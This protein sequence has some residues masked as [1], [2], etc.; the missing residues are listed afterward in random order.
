MYKML[1]EKVVQDFCKK[2]AEKI[3]ESLTLL[4]PNNDTSLHM[5]WR[6]TIS[7]ARKLHL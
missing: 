6:L 3:G 2:I 1:T 4:V 7:I 5:R